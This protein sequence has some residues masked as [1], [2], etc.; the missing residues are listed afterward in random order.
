MVNDLAE[1]KKTILIV[2]DTP[3]NLAVLGEL[4]MPHYQVRAANSGAKALTVTIADP[5]P[6][7]I[8][9]D[10]MMPGMDGYEVLRR[11]KDDPQT[12]DIPVMFITALD[13]PED[14]VRGLELGAVDFI[15]K[16]IRPPVVLARVRGQLELKEAR[17]LLRDKNAWL[18]N[19]VKR[20]VRQHQKIQNASMRALASLAEARDNETGNHILRTQSYVNVLAEELAKLP[21]YAEI[22]LPETI[23]S[24]TK[25]ATLHD[26]GKVGV[27]DH[28]L[29]KPGKHTPEE[30]D[31]MKTHA[32]IGAQAIWR[33]IKDEDDREAVT[34]LQVAMD[35]AGNH[36]E[37][38]DGS[39]YPKGLSG[40]QIPLSA[41]LMAV[42]DVFDALLRTGST[43]LPSAL[44]K[45]VRLSWKTVA[46]TSIL[47]S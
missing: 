28:I 1:S 22:L 8:L 9:L 21:H 6:D 37:K 23:E 5:R 34:F 30:W 14:E 2:D 20:R 4:L 29:Y 46:R 44:K 42:A 33:A 43:S 3:A 7:L 36:H 41:R 25:A 11:L 12:Q 27:P 15:S 31:I 13:Q 45:P 35:I 39:G 40:E 18:D 17:D 47:K 10:V 24:Y 32:E 26:I 16:P 19:E 38:W